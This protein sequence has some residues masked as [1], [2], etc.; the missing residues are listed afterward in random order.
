M[1]PG[2]QGTGA[3]PFKGQV[4]QGLGKSLSC[5][6]VNPSSIPRK[7]QKPGVAASA[8]I[9]DVADRGKQSTEPLTHRPG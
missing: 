5:K 6:Q 3:A 8:V 7:S 1:T 2:A 9:P 4:L